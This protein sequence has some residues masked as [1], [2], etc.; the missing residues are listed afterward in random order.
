MKLSVVVAVALVTLAA[1]ALALVARENMLEPQED[2]F[3]Q[4]P[5][6][7][8]SKEV[9][10]ILRTRKVHMKTLV[11]ENLKEAWQLLYRTTYRTKDEPTTTVTTVM[12]PHNAQNDSLVMFGDFEDTGAPQCAPSYTWRAGLTSDVSS[13][14]NVAIAMLYLQEG[15]IVTMPDKEGKKGAFASG[16]VEGRQSLDGIRATLAF[17]KI[18]LKKEAKVVGH[19]YSGGGIQTGWTAALKKTYAPEINTVGWVTGG[20]PT[21]LTALVE[22]I[23]KG[24]FAGYVAGGLTGLRSTYPEVKAYTDKVFTKEGRKDMAYPMEHC[25]VEVVLHFAFKDFFD[26]RISTNGKGYLYEAVVQ[27]VLEEMTMGTNKEY[28]PDTPVLMAHGV[29][30]EIAPYEAA[31]K[32]YEAW[33]KNGGEV[34]FLSYENALAGHVGIYAT[35]SVPGFLWNRERLQGKRVEGGCREYKNYDLGVNTNALGE[36]FESTLKVL[37]GLMGDKIGPNDEYLRDA[38]H[39]R[40]RRGEERKKGSG[41]GRK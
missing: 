11:E 21:N 10:T 3:Y 30:D 33:C 24:P 25:Q 23:N 12:V 29:A 26:K 31:H 8:E 2:P 28:T 17:D 14:A 13:I 19:G 5:E 41:E 37:K 36:E 22:R 18:G 35:S 38:I 40:E 4:P 6:G 32:T 20:T 9:G 16:H 1:Q 39:K 15:Y 7:W 34:E 27:K